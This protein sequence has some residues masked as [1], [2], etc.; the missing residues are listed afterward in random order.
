MTLA[1]QALAASHAQGQSNPAKTQGQADG[2]GKM[3]HKKNVDCTL[4][5]RKA[6]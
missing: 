5:Q 6:S 2:G 3:L 1:F 4:T